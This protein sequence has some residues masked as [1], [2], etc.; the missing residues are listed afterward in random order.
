MLLKRSDILLRTEVSSRERLCWILELS[1]TP[2]NPVGLGGALL[3]LAGTKLNSVINFH[4]SFK[5]Y[6]APLLWRGHVGATHNQTKHN[7]IE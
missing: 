1:W 2:W 7:R 3:K 5:A 4:Y 6:S